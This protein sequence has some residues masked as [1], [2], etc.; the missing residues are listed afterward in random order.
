ML[1]VVFWVLLLLGVPGLCLAGNEL[2]FVTEVKGKAE[3]KRQ[4]GE[5]ETAVVGSRLFAGDVLRALKGD[6]ALIY[7]SG[8][9]VKLA[10]GEQHLGAA[11][12]E[13]ATSL[14]IRLKETLDEID[15]AGGQGPTVHGMARGLGQITGAIP[16]NTWLSNSDFAFSWDS[17][18]GVHQYQFTLETSEGKVLRREM[19]KGNRLPAAGM[20]LEKGRRYLWSAS[21]P[22][23]FMPRTTGALWIELAGEKAVGEL[24]T[25][26]NGIAQIY[27]GQT[28]SLLQAT[29]LYKAG[30]YFE[31]CSALAGQQIKRE[32]SP[33]EKSL[34]D[35]AR[36][37]MEP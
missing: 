25:T 11:E 13:A 22:G 14:V 19:V 18:E 16:A 2:A 34:L 28:Q 35:K 1:K 21:D 24:T 12:K 32:L 10:E 17:L 33:A 37:K 31:A 20:E 5:T 29:V 26:L 9:M 7:L 27:Q 15:Q 6:V 4:A 36:A 8:R 23:G 3:I 30:F